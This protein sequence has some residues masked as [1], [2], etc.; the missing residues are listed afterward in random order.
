MAIDWTDIYKKNKGLW[1]ALLNDEKTVVGR[2][3]TLKSAMEMA[4]K[5]GH[6]DPIFTRM[7]NK[8]NTYIGSL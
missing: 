6:K 5:K 3:K 2:G 1:V 7:P 4:H 8:I